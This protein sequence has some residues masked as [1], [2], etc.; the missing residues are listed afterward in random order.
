MGIWGRGGILGA[1]TKSNHVVAEGINPHN[2]INLLIQ[3]FTKGI[4]HFPLHILLH[5]LLQPDFLNQALWGLVEANFANPPLDVTPALSGSSA[6]HAGGVPPLQTLMEFSDTTQE[7][8]THF[9]QANVA[10]GV[11]LQSVYATNSQWM[12]SQIDSTVTVTAVTTCS[13]CVWE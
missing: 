3:G 13:D 4:T 6:E 8:W 2:F 10:A 9:I 7:V 5:K 1:I 12:C 11:F